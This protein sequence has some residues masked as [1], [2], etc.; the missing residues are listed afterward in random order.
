MAGIEIVIIDGKTTL[1]EFRKELRYNE[2]YYALN[3]G[4]GG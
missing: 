4:I 3:R 1:R 2:V